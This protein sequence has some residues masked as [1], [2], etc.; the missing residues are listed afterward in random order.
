MT[1]LDKLAALWD[2]YPNSETTLLGKDSS[3]FKVRVWG[4]AGAKPFE[5][6]LDSLHSTQMSGVWRHHRDEAPIPALVKLLLGK[7]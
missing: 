1:R 5:S 3:G 2:F 7:T 4:V 6:F